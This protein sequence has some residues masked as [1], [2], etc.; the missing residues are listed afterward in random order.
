MNQVVIV[1]HVERGVE[2][3]SHHSQV[4]HD[5]KLDL[6]NFKHNF[7]LKWQDINVTQNLTTSFVTDSTIPIAHNNI[8]LVETIILVV[9]YSPSN[10]LLFKCYT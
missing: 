3:D 10:T 4:F 6:Q 9:G 8:E 5:K 7:N 2:M 1:V